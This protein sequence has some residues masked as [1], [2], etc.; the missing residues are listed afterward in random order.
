MTVVHD[1]ESDSEG[2]SGMDAN[3]YEL[4]YGL[5]SELGVEKEV[6]DKDLP[7]KPCNNCACSFYIPIMI[8]HHL[9]FLQ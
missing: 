4:L 5:E 2:D 8:P 7:T 6:E 3:L 1:E 9:G